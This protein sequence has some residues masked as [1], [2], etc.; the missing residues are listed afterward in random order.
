MG[1]FQ[2]HVVIDHYEL[3]FQVCTGELVG[4]DL[5]DTA[6]VHAASEQRVHHDA[7]AA[8]A[9]AAAADQ[10]QHPLTFGGG[11]QTVA[12]VLLQGRDILRILK[13]DSHRSGGGAPGL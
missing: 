10:H 6:C 4:L 3:V 7:D 8:F 12:H 13:N 5:S 11:D 9:L 2:L 1:S